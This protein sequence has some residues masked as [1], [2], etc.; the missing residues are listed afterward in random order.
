M[1]KDDYVDEDGKVHMFEQ[2]WSGGHAV[3]RHVMM[4]SLAFNR[5]EAG[6]DASFDED[7]LRLRVQQMKEVGEMWY[8]HSSIMSEPRTYEV[9]MDTVLN[10][11]ELLAAGLRVEFDD[12]E[13]DLNEIEQMLNEGKKIYV[14]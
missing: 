12:W 7:A 1:Y 2:V 3:S 5:H 10:T 14:I 11:R 9:T 6:I 4:T 13:K 8:S